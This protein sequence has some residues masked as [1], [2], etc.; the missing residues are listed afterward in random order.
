MR[1]HQHGEVLPAGTFFSVSPKSSKRE[2]QLQTLA[3]GEQ[4]QGRDNER[5]RLGQLVSWVRPNYSLVRANAKL[6][7]QQWRL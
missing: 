6:S 2:L 5:A 4:E 7:A 1:G 3:G